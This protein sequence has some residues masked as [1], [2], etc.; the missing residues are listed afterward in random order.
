[1]SKLE[2]Q[3][4]VALGLEMRYKR[5]WWKVKVKG[6]YGEDA[7]VLRVLGETVGE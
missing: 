2:T 5:G 4:G 1:L 6:G 7:Q 3:G